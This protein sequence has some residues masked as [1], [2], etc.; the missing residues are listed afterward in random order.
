MS[1]A[2]RIRMQKELDEYRNRK[3]VELPEDFTYDIPAIGLAWPLKYGISEDDCRGYGFG[4]SDKYQR[5]VMPVHDI[6][7]DSLRAVQSRAVTNVT[8]KYLNKG[9]ALFFA[10]SPLDALGGDSMVITEDMLSCVK[11]GKVIPAV[12]TLGTYL[13]AKDASKLLELY[14]K[15]YVWYDDDE[16]GHRGS[17]QARRELQMQGAHVRIINTELDPKEYS[18]RE[19]K[20]ILDV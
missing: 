14:S 2:E 13:S 5:F 4:W 1:V 10:Y 3:T 19:I 11:V 17:K 20:E 7:D 12:S 8:P 6:H 9:K 18:T 16:A 15:F